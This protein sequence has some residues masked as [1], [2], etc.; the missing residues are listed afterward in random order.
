MPTST[1]IPNPPVKRARRSLRLQ[2]SVGRRASRLT[3]NAAPFSISCSEVDQKRFGVRTAKALGVTAH[4]LPQMVS[5][6][7][8]HQ[9]RLLIA[10]SSADDSHAARSIER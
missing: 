6:C 10:R 9:V 2:A 1:W 7:H 5:F 8:A 3:P 4:V